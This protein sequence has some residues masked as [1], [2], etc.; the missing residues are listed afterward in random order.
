M[1]LAV[2]GLALFLLALAIDPRAGL[3]GWLFAAVV[4]ATISFGCLGVFFMR[5]LVGLDGVEGFGPALLAGGETL[6]VVA[7]AFIPVLLGL[8][9]LY[10]WVVAPPDN[11]FQKLWLQSGF[12]VIRTVVYFLLW[13]GLAA[14]ALKTA[15]RPLAVAGLLILGIS[16]SMAA[17]DW[18][19]SLEPRFHSSIYGMLYL[20]HA[21]LAGWAFSVAVSLLSGRPA[22][23][24]MA[25]G[26]I[27]GGIAFWAYLSF[28]QYLVI[29]NGNE[30]RE[31]GWYLAREKESWGLLFWAASFLMGILPFLFLLLGR[32]RASRSAVGIIAVVL[33]AGTILQTG[34]LILPAFGTGAAALSAVPAAIGL[35]GVWLLVFD[36]RFRRLSVLSPE[37]GHG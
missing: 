30:P 19:M 23:P 31:I 10:P 22:P 14:V 9:S 7:V 37:T 24:R 20:T 25:A 35:G 8:A 5:M 17:V 36:H 12:F 27:I 15:S 21:A 26:Y 6:P 13:V 4:W 11:V 1:V 3:Q 32:M 2:A 18:M 16:G 33:V 29:W 34:V 28:C